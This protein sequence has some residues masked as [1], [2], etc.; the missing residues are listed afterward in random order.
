M[1]ADPITWLLSSV[2]FALAMCATPGPNN[3]M[4]T[5][6][7]ATF[8]F[9]ATIPHMLGIAVG[10]SMML[11]VLALGGGNVFLD[12]PSIH[13]ALKW[14]GVAYLLWLAF[15]IAT[16]RPTL[17]SATA[18]RP[19]DRS[20]RKPLSFIRAALFQWVNPKASVIGLSAIATYTHA[21]QVVGQTLILA[22]VFLLICLPCVAFWTLTGVGAARLL[23][24][25]RAIRIFNLV[26]AS[27]LVASLLPIVVGRSL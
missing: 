10:F 26:L 3:T 25:E 22:A 5:A 12:H 19:A 21:G 8:G 4:V 9:R 16:A 18:E 15:H 27:L 17:R 2:A 24:T 1:N 6:S 23:R 13:L 20:N 14:A 11:I 7:G